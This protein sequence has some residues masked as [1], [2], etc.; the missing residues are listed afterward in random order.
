MD[1]DALF[2]I[3]YTLYRTEADTPSSSD[4]E[5]VIFTALSTEAISRWANYENVF[6]KELYSTLQIAQDGDLTLAASTTEYATPADMRIAG[7][8]VRI[9]D[10]ATNQTKARIPI[11]EPQQAQFQ[12]DLRSYCYFIGDPNNGFTLVINPAP[13][14][15]LVGMSIDYV[16]YK[17]PTIFSSG[18][19]GGGSD[20]TEMSQ[21]MFI[22][23]RAL[24]NRFRG[25]RNPYYQSAKNDAE[26]VLQT[27]Q[28]ENNSGNWSDPWQL[29][30]NSSGRFGI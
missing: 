19:D 8:Y 24:A 2:N 3:Y 6:W 7:G 5:Y 13:V 10:P 4:D 27:M 20:V 16:Y 21:P 12:T 1:Q 11:I 25:S 18:A 28:A 22:V 14:D 23:H 17:K 9:F 15:A 26:D 30:D 29:A